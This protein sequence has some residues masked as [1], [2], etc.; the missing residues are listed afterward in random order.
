[1]AAD[2]GGM[3]LLAEA[4]L[5]FRLGMEGLAGNRL[6]R[7]IDTLQ[8]VL[9]ALPPVALARTLPLLQQVLAA[10]QRRDFVQV[11]DLL[12]YELAPVWSA[13]VREDA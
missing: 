12:Q 5:A 2:T 13:V 3:E 8:R 7:F 4:V 10:Q 9:A 11:A 1:M 6:A